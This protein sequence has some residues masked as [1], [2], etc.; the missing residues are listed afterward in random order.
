VFSVAGAVRAQIKQDGCINCH[1][2]AGAS[3]RT[4]AG[5]KKKI[6]LLNSGWV[7]NCRCCGSCSVGRH[8]CC[9][10]FSNDLQFLNSFW[11]TE[12]NGLCCT[13]IFDYFTENITFLLHL[14]EFLYR[15]VSKYVTGSTNL[16]LGSFVRT[17]VVSKLPFYNRNK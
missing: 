15:D 13:N 11:S 6:A 17:S 5:K 7:V 4:A 1:V 16:Q 8:T 9:Q 10:H 2:M 14:V 3:N 12:C